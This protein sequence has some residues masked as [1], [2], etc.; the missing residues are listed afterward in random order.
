[1]VV[2]SLKDLV[3]WYANKKI[4]KNQKFLSAISSLLPRRHNFPSWLL[5]LFRPILVMPFCFFPLCFL[6][7]IMIS[8]LV[9]IYMNKII[10]LSVT[11]T[12][13]Y[14]SDRF[15][16]NFSSLLCTALRMPFFLAILN[17][18][19]PP[20]DVDFARRWP[21]F[22]FHKRTVGPILEPPEP[23]DGGFVVFA[24]SFESEAIG[25]EAKQYSIIISF[26]PIPLKAVSRSNWSLNRGTHR[27]ET[28]CNP[29]TEV[30]VFYRIFREMWFE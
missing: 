10:V 9:A 5:S 4:I 15:R 23:R 12:G 17:C 21:L 30:I 22:A 25:G 20:Y 18:H 16:W 28:F 24:K 26:I 1:M 6:F 7:I 8:S 2:R 27:L 29:K 3:F 11:L 13:P 14:L 19:S